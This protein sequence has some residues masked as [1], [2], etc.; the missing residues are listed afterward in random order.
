MNS[1]PSTSAEHLT[2]GDLVR[3]LDEEM[4]LKERSQAAAHLMA[5][6]A[7]SAELESLRAGRLQFADLT[8]EIDIPRLDSTRRRDS[9]RQIERAAAGRTTRPHRN[10]R[11]GMLRAAAIAAVLVTTAVATS[12]VR[13]LLADIWQGVSDQV[14]R[15]AGIDSATEQ[16]EGVALRNATI[17]FVPQGEIFELEVLSTQQ[18][19]SLI[20][21]VA[22]GASV[23]ARIMGDDTV[24]MVVLPDGLRIEN[25]SDATAD[26][27]VSLPLHLEEIRVR[28]AGSAEPTVYSMEDL[29]ESWISVVDLSASND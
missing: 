10:D 24:D 3:Y 25:D 21:G 22:E 26:Y 2:E 29:T 6:R 11:A 4:T 13:A 7:C 1:T 14:E 9:W 8:A 18:Q 16:P 28:V 23:T 27:T 15:I 20:L 19:G 17:G 12:P 5:C